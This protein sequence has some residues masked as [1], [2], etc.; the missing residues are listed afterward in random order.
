MAG[1]MLLREIAVTKPA[2]DPVGVHL[3]DATTCAEGPSVVFDATFLSLDVEGAEHLVLEA[4]DPSAFALLIVER[5]YRR[6]DPQDVRLRKRLQDAK[7]E[8]ANTLSVAKSRV[9]VRDHSI[10][11]PIVRR[12]GS[13]L[14]KN[15]QPIACVR[16]RLQEQ[17]Q[18]AEQ[19]A[20]QPTGTW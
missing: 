13:H 11:L 17:K 1:K 14:F 7:T 18:R 5:N 3:A 12:G 8:P 19:K 15:Q 9:Y 16:R 4:A 2:G 6:K 10:E 20:F